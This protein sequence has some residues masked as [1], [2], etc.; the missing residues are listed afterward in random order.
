MLLSLSDVKSS[1][2][3]TVAPISSSE[4]R[5]VESRDE[6]TFKTGVVGKVVNTE[7]RFV[8]SSRTLLLRG[9]VS[10]AGSTRVGAT[11]HKEEGEGSN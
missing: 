4:A 10:E 2:A 3:S 9:P 5:P 11:D 1:V 7:I 8:S 6:D